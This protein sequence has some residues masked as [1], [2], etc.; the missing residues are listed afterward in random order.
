MA[1]YS[2]RLKRSAAKENER[3]GT[4]RDRRRIVSRIRALASDPRPSGFQKLSGI[5]EL[6]RIRQGDYRIVYVGD[7]D[8]KNVV[9]IK[10]GHR[11]VIYR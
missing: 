10:V 3:V 6:Y 4:Q 11:K 1:G 7:D 5:E 2:I 8:D 9:V